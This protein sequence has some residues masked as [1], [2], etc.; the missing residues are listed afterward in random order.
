LFEELGRETVV[1]GRVSDGELE[2]LPQRVTVK[3]QGIVAVRVVLS[4]APDIKTNEAFHYIF[5]EVIVNLLG[6]GWADQ[7]LDV[8]EH[9][10]QSVMNLRNR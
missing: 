2:G 3:G 1:N 8:G 5:A 7:G 4:S 6:R 10:L 9:R